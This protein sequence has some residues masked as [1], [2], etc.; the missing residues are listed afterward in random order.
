V[1]ST[2]TATDP[3]SGVNYTMYKVDSGTW[4]TYTAP[5]IIK[6]NGL[7]TIHFYSIDN[8]GNIETE[9][10]T[11]FTIQYPIQITIKGGLGISATIKNN[12]T[13]TVTNMNWSIDLSGGIILLGKSNTGTIANLAAGQQIKV[14]DFVFGFG[15]PVIT[16]TVGDSTATATGTVLLFFVIGVA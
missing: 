1:T 16:V 11:T 9:K 2:L 3:G 8:A 12:G 7:H 4:T 15:K 13:T 6:G 10:T 5:F 14:S